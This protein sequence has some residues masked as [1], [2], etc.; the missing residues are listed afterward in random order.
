LKNLV[1]AAKLMNLD[2]LRNR[3]LDAAAS[4]IPENSQNVVHNCHERLAHY[5]TVA[6]RQFEHLTN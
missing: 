5:Q 1:F 2:E 6:G 4:I 3:I